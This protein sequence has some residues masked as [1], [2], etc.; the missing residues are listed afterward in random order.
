MSHRYYTVKD[1]AG[2]LKMDPQIIRI[3]CR[4]GHLPAIK[5]P[6]TRDW[7]IPISDME[8]VLW[9][10]EY[11][12]AMVTSAGVTW[13]GACSMWRYLLEVWWV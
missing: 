7:R 12:D 3:K 4:K 6:G 10:M 2:M 5:A 11:S 8:T 13:S 9:E 1:I